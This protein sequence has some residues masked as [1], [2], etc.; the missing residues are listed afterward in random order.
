MRVIEERPQTVSTLSIPVACIGEEGHFFEERASVASIQPPGTRGIAIREVFVSGRFTRMGGE[1][2]FRGRLQGR[3]SEACFRCLSPAHV[4]IYLEVD[5]VYTESAESGFRELAQAMEMDSET[6]VSADANDDA[7]HVFHGP[8]IDLGPQVWE[9]LVFATPSRYLC[10]EFC[11]GICPRC[12]VDLNKESCRCATSQVEPLAGNSGLAR[13]A[14]LFPDLAG[15]QN[16][17]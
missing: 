8:E 6:D 16:E 2:L 5:W 4:D 7:S 11:K 17:E 15:Q 3:F 10:R 13:L 9:E 1:F 12:G 14:E